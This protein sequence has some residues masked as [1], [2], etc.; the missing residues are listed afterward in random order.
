[1]V[2]V[3]REVEFVVDEV[4]TGRCARETE[5]ACIGAGAERY[6]LLPSRRIL[7][8]ETV[9]KIVNGDGADIGA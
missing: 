8:Q 4:G 2:G 5:E 6:D 7:R 1:M 9:D 3:G